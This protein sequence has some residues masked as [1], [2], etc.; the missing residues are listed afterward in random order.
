MIRSFR[1]PRKVSPRPWAALRSTSPSEDDRVVEFRADRRGPAVA[2]RPLDALD[3][4]RA[5][6]R[7]GAR[8]GVQLPSR[9]AVHG[10]QRGGS[11][12]RCRGRRRARSRRGRR[13]AR[14]WR[15]RRSRQPRRV[16]RRRHHAG[17]DRH[18]AHQRRVRAH[19]RRPVGVGDLVGASGQRGARARR[20]CAATPSS[21]TSCC[22]RGTRASSTACT[23]A[24]SPPATPSRC[25]CR[26]ARPRA[27]P[28][29]PACAHRRCAPP[30]SSARP[31]RA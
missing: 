6:C 24:R 16:H 12:G 2:H 7:H 4:I 27:R 1:P 10:W 5:R 29:P 22:T 20:A 15:R 14:R 31:A 11:R 9:A 17:G 25:A 23:S 13:R 30:P 26:A 3:P 8:S 19:A 28:R 21:A 18:G